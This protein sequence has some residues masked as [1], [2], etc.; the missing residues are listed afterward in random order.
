[1][2]TSSFRVARRIPVSTGGCSLPPRLGVLLAIVFWGVSFVATRAVVAQ[3]SPVALI[4][5]RAA[6]GSLL[7]VAILTARGREWWPARSFWPS[8]LLMGFIGV[9]LHGLLQA[10]ALQLTSAIN[11]G[12]LIGLTPIWSA[13]LAALHLRERFPPRKLVGLVLGFLGA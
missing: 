13:I 9:A 3:I 2:N 4:F 6:L 5:A 8:L 11:S 1:M 10:Y 12:W 7:L